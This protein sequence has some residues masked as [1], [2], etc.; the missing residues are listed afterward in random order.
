[1]ISYY[2]DRH[3]FL[4]VYVNMWKEQVTSLVNDNSV[5]HTSEV[6]LQK[7]DNSLWHHFLNFSDISLNHE[8]LNSEKLNDR[9]LSAH[10]V[11]KFFFYWRTQ[12]PTKTKYHDSFFLQFKEQARTA[13]AVLSVGD[14]TWCDMQP[15][16]WNNNLL[17]RDLFHFSQR[18]TSSSQFLLIMMS[19]FICR[20][21]NLLSD[22]LLQHSTIDW[23]I[24]CDTLGIAL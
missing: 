4:M 18:K 8:I 7:T 13:G 19:T 12:I 2:R 5:A 6:T 20:E 23:N 9:K 15:L 17:R 21:N 3:D 10:C 14:E 1:M 16:N 11:L 24:Y 22:F